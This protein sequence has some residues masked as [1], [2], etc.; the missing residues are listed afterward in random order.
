[1]SD[2]LRPTERDDDL[3]AS[4]SAVSLTEPAPEAASRRK[5]APLTREEEAK[6]ALE[7]TAISPAAAWLLTAA[8]L[9]TI[10]VVP[11][12][13]GVVEVGRNRAARAEAAASG[14]PSSPAL[15]PQSLRFLSLLPSWDEIRSAKTAKD[16][17][18]LIPSPTRLKAFENDLE[19]ESVASAYFLPRAQS[20]LTR[21]FGTGND[22]AYVGREGWLMY[23]P[24]VDYL[25]SRGFLDP[26]L[27]RVR[28]RSGGE[29]TEAVQPDPLKAIS[30]FR[31]QLSS[32]DIRLIV[33]PTPLKP[34]I[35]P[36][37]FSPR[38]SSSPVALQNP[39]YDAFLRAAEREGVFVFD[40]TGLLEEEKRRT[41][42]PQYLKTDTHWTPEAMEAAA[43][44]L[45]RFIRKNID[46][47]ETQPVRYLRHDAEAVNTGDIARMLK[48]P[49]SAALFPDQ[50]AHLRR[51]MEPD[52]RKWKPDRRAD[53][54]LLGDSF[55][56]I[57]S[58]GGM[59]WGD[60]AG[61]AEQ[62]SFYLRR[63]LDRIA[64]NAGGS[65]SA[66]Q[67]MVAEMRRGKDRLKGKRL[68]IWQFAMRDL[69]S[70]DWK[71]F[72]LPD[73]PRR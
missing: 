30:Q 38:Y 21:R 5:E 6:L 9:L 11:V 7:H 68:V 56:N 42:R 62:L 55:T 72:D 67:Q 57:Y 15:F 37:R 29:E 35:E 45:A 44:G 36:E 61:F 50:R 2:T 24:D 19:D 70:G 69:L 14:D 66:R 49:D 17:W 28:K 65:Y 52:G 22:E 43:K 33:M 27:L 8:F 13:Q 58:L 31:R 39:S 46:L 53:I 41:G 18:G 1:M 63:P 60:S 26:A 48:L 47:P 51:I 73:A 32:R 10:F 20:A 34:M 54:L 71:L 23:R 25:T 4:D 64:I 3:P 12:L 16:A 40:P 59:G